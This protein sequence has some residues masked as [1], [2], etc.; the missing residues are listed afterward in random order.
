MLN[1][2][3]M[4]GGFVLFIIAMLILDLKVLQ[5]RSHVMP[6]KEALLWV[7]FWVSLALIFN[8]GIYFYFGMDSAL[9]FL[10]GYLV[11]YSLSV[12]NIFVFALIFSYFGIPSEYRHKALL[13]GILGAIVMR[14]IFILAGVAMINRLHWIIYVFGAFL[15]YIGIKI[16]FEKDR[17]M[18]PGKNPILRLVK[19]F[20]PVTESY[21]GGRFF[22]R[23]AGRL[24][25]TPM[26]IVVIV[27][28]TTDVIF[29][30]DSIPAILSITL[31][32]FIVYTSNIFAILGLRALYFALA[33]IMDLFHYL[34]YG[35]A[36]ILVFVGV[37]M[38]ISDYYKI[39][40]AGALGFIVLVLATSI[41][42]S[43]MFPKKDAPSPHGVPD[44]R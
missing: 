36:A 13:W 6:V 40:V 42:A 19:R 10:T 26:L 20:L 8:V 44:K 43:I 5:R 11:E 39:P 37:K 38:L 7:A 32:P 33:G 31:N 30:V 12:D 23:R 3:L 9:E 1:Q 17:E 15:V 14:A 28:E 22:V 25:A 4:W 41:V 27:I 21:E 18:D 24:F 34:N 35:L 16:A 2:Y 29:A